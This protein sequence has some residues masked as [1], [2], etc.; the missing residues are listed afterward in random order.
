MEA[1]GEGRRRVLVVDDDEGIRGL[2]VALLEDEGYEVRAASDGFKALGVLDAWSCDVVLTDLSMPLM[3]GL[4][5]LRRVVADRP[6][7]DCVLMTA[8]GGVE[9]AVEAMKAGAADYLLKPLDIEAVLLVLERVIERRAL[10][11]EVEVLRERL[12]APAAGA[13]MLGKSAPM[14][15]L[16]RRISQVATSRAT[17]LIQGESGTGKELVAQM[18]H[19]QSSRSDKPF[20][21]LHCAALSESL[22]ESELFGHERGSFTGATSR[23]AGRFEEAHGG[24]LFLEEIGEVPLSIQVKLLRFLQQRQFERV[25]GNQTI[26]VDVRVVAA[27]HRD[28][29]Q[30]VREGR[31]REDLYY[32]L[33]VVQLKTPPLSSRRE[34]IPLL[35]RHFVARFAVENGRG[36]LTVSGEALQALK[37]RPWPGNVRELE[38]A[39]ESAVVMAEGDTIEARHLSEEGE[40]GLVRAGLAEEIHVPGATL[41]DIERFAILSTLASVGGSTARTAEILDI[42]VRKV[43]Y[44]IKA[45]AEDK[46]DP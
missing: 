32:R 13:R 29:R 7:Q 18:I 11:R 25:G 3:D 23:R 30:E 37:A 21:R 4:A 6:Y 24:T 1:E 12:K 22:L 2:V 36:A 41:A 45:Y 43:R 26:E 20:V 8:H 34:D 44:K 14:A 31:F 38:N 28:L 5:L 15:E 10:R 33:N 40:V 9:S 46:G 42:S 35:V 27:T 19:A 17:V 39:M 16:K